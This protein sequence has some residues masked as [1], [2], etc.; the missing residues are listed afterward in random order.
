MNIDRKI[1]LG[2]AYL[3]TGDKNAAKDCFDKA[4][5]LTKKEAE[6]HV[7]KIIMEIAEACLSSGDNSLAE[8]YYKDILNSKKTYSSNDIFLFNRL[9]ISL[10]RQGKWKEAIKE[11]EKVLNITTENPNIYYNIAMAQM[12]GNLLEEAFKNFENSYKLDKN[13]ILG[14]ELFI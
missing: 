2:S 9:G 13:F 3:T 12:E 8:E 4:K 6:R 11:Y 1:E 5:V 14:N 10:R 7:E